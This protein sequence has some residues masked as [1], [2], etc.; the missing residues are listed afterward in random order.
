MRNFIGII[1]ILICFIFPLHFFIIGDGIGFGF[2]G[3]FYQYKESGYGTSFLPVTADM[4]YIFDGIYK[5]K[6]MISVLFWV[7]G[8]LCIMA[9]T[10]IWLIN[11]SGIL[12]FDLLSGLLFIV[13]GVTYLISVMFQYGV[14]FFGSAGISVPFGIPLLIGVGYLM[15]K[16]GNLDLKVRRE[17]L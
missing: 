1:L 17:E 9:S 6:T 8:S 10:I 4:N 2:Q 7:L 5:G 15:T 3:V 13:A 16:F 12:R 14:F 11:N